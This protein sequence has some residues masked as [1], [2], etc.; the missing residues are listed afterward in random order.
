MALKYLM[1]TKEVSSTRKKLSKER[2]ARRN[3]SHKIDILAYS[4]SGILFNSRWV[5]EALLVA[6]PPRALKGRDFF[7]SFF[8]LLFL[9]IRNMSAFP[10]FRSSIYTQPLTLSSSAVFHDILPARRAR[11]SQYPLALT[12]GRLSRLT[13]AALYAQI[14]ST[15]PKLTITPRNA[16]RRTS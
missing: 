5:S 11:L 1:K 16:Y 14:R 15:R 4:R 12:A 10:L 7:S 8:L 9:N 2:L 13:L 6:C 3:A